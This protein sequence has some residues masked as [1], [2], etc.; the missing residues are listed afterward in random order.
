MFNLTFGGM[1]CL[2]R[3][4]YSVDET[5]FGQKKGEGVIWRYD[6]FVVTSPLELYDAESSLFTQP[7]VRL[8]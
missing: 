1:M 6:S 2:L 8:L 5:R 4:W 3:P 7:C